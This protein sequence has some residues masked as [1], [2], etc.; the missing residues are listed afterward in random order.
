[1]RSKS[2]NATC[3]TCVDACASG[4]L[5]TTESGS[6]HLHASACNQCGAC[7]VAC[8]VKAI[9]GNLP[10]RKT[11]EQTLFEDNKA[12]LTVKELLLYHQR[13]Y[14]HVVIES[15]VSQWYTVIKQANEMLTR[16]AQPLLT[17]L[18]D[19]DVITE[20]ISKSRRAF[21]RVDLLN[22]SKT[23]SDIKIENQLLPQAFAD[24]QFFTVKLDKESC[25]LCSACLRLCPTFAIKYEQQ[26]FVID[27]GRCVGCKSCEDGCPEQSLKVQESI[28]SKTISRT[29]FVFNICSECKQNY[30]ALSNNHAL[31]TP[32]KVRKLLNLGTSGMLNHHM[33]I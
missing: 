33:N 13:A 8:P 30:L 24:Y 19:P 26:Q 18:F 12:L 10:I 9:E 1:M 17:F 14:R 28:Q 5:L 7:V 29:P 4:A 3:H 25:S 6:L 22:K 21:L 16:L 2:K 23:S 15:E 27:N 31:C 11:E 20:Q 32:C